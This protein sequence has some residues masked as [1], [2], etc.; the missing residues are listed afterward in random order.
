[1]GVAVTVGVNGIG[2][3]VT[4]TVPGALGQVVIVFVA[5]TEK[6]P[7]YAVVIPPRVGF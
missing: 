2:F 3:T 4:V 6:G 5:T 1:L 7:L